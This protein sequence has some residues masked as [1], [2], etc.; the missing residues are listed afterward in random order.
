MTGVINIKVKR[1]AAS[2]QNEA[3]CQEG[4]ELFKKLWNELP[5][6]VCSAIKEATEATQLQNDTQKHREMWLAR[7]FKL[8]K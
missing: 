7:C 2:Q 5:L 1:V 8:N 3:L 6:E 4:E